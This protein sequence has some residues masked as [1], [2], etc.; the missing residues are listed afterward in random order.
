LEE[1]GLTEKHMKVSIRSL[2]EYV[3][4]SGSIDLRFRTSQSMVEGTKAHQKLQNAYAE[5]DLKEVPLQTEVEYNGLTYEIEGRTDGILFED[6]E[7]TIDEI[8]STSMELDSIKEVG[9]PVHW[10]QAKFYAYIYAKDHHLN[11]I[12]VRLTYYQVLTE[13]VKRLV[14]TFQMAEL[15]AFVLETVAEYAP[16]AEMRLM[17]LKERNESIK[18]LS[19]PFEQFRTG[20][21]KLAGA[22]YK[23]ISDKRNLFAMAPTG[24]G[25]TIST[26]FPSIKAMGEDK[27]GKLYYLTAKTITRQAAEEAFHL[28]QENGLTFSSV[29]ITA[30]EKACLKEQMICQKDYCEF[31]NGYYDRL[32]EAVLDIYK[33]ESAINRSTIERYAIKHTLCPFEF[34]LDLSYLA[35]AVICDYNYIFDPRVSLKRLLE[36]QK[37]ET[38]LLIDEAHNLVDRAREMFSAELWKSPFLTLKKEYQDSKLSLFVAAKAIN[39]LFLALKKEANTKDASIIDSLSTEFLEALEQF[40]AEA[41]VALLGQA[42][43]KTDEV[44][45]ENYFL[46]QNFLRIY[47]LIDNRFTIYLEIDRSEV[48][49]KIFCLDPSHQLKQMS[50]GFRSMIYFSA[51]LM[52]IDYYQH[53]L[54][55]TDE[56]YLIGI[57]SPFRQE[58]IEFYI[59]PLSTRFK[60]RERTKR[61]IANLILSFVK[62]RSGNFLVFFPSYQYMMTVYE[63]INQEALPFDMLIQTQ[64]M[65]EE[66]KEGFLEHFQPEQ[67]RSLVGFAVMGGI[68]SEGVDLKGNRL[69]GVFVVGVGLPQIGFERD[70]IKEYFDQIGKNGYDYA[71]VYPGI[72]KV[73]QA[74][75]RLIRSESDT[76]LIVLIDDRFR[77]LKYQKLLPNEWIP[78]SR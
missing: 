15:E 64:G 77:Q 58:Q 74:G 33:N 65:S 75:G 3:F 72:N 39:A 7:V 66:E 63:E 36:D 10:A 50:K 4:S 24:I 8:K 1:R 37:R 19:F 59:E 61:Q 27:C 52:P 21:R 43:G 78:L 2:V 49:L 17:H 40:K 5:G 16:F 32:N 76:G 57:P 51:T 22:V 30:K 48:K 6:N 46:V 29:T 35:D 62:N 44:L 41:E 20:Q 67:P 73:L 53:L 42:G 47:K 56:D 14:Q 60:D 54:G 38:V 68:F 9:I 13:E 25:K 11:Q 28:M 18:T 71:Y 26:T 12:N 23:T 69:N 34:S 70:L 45:L 31:A 55:A